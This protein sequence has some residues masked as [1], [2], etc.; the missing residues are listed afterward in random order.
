MANITFEYLPNINNSIVSVEFLKEFP[1]LRSL[2]FFVGGGFGSAIGSQRDIYGRNIY[3]LAYFLDSKV[4]ADLSFSDK[5]SLRIGGVYYLAT[6]YSDWYIEEFKYRVPLDRVPIKD[7]NLS[8]LRL[9]VG[10]SF[11]F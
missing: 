6:P 2:S 7:Y 5:L 10:I 9:N 3:S 11:T 1:L 4:F 8:G